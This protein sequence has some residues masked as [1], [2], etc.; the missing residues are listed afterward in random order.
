MYAIVN[1]SGKQFK[2]E[3]GKIAIVPKLVAQAGDTITFD[4]ILL[5]QDGSSTQIGNPILSGASITAN[6]IEHK[7]SKKIL[8]YKKKRRKGYQ[9]KNGHRQ[10]YTEIK[11]A[12]IEVPEVK[13]SDKNK[14][15][16]NQKLSEEEE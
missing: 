14:V 11:F 8:V 7:R 9:R 12:T 5:I 16:L 15:L 10:W 3:K 2:A 6:V 4:K 1:I 13:S